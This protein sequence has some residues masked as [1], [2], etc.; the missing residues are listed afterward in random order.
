MLSEVSAWVDLRQLLVW[1]SARAA[2]S[3]ALQQYFQVSGWPGR[4]RC[5]TPIRPPPA[6][7]T[8]PAIQSA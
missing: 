4:G 3:R 6:R 7:P 1:R 5:R 8:R 2:R